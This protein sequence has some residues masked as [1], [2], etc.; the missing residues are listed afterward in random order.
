LTGEVPELA[1]AA[2]AAGDVAAEED[3][4]ERDDDADAAAADRQPA[5]ADPA[6]AEVLDLRGVEL[7]LVAEVGHLCAQPDSS[8]DRA[9][10]MT[11]S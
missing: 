1:Q 8:G 4:E 5:L 7:R 10:T 11:T 2:V 6:A 9:S 3:D